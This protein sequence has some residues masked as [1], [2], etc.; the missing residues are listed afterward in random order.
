[1][2]SGY[3]YSILLFRRCKLDSFDERFKHSLITKKGR[4]VAEYITNNKDKVGFMTANAIAN[5]LGISDVTVIR[6]ARSLGYDG[7]SDMQSELQSLAIQKINGQP[8]FSASPGAKIT[9][10]TPSDENAV[11]DLVLNNTLFNID[12]MI[13]R[14]TTRD[15]QQAADIIIQSRKKYVIGFL[16]RSVFSTHLA[17][18]LRF[19]LSDVINITSSS[20]NALIPLLDISSHDCVILYSYNKDPSKTLEVAHICKDHGAKIIIITDNEAAQVNADSDASLIAIVDG[21]SFSNYLAVHLL[22]DILVTTIAKQLG[23]D[24]EA[25]FKQ[26]KSLSEHVD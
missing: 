19:L 21:I 16:A 17:N 13:K 25:R 14:N 7:Y 2:K 1:M 4:L 5:E 11:K 24:Q 9:A 3:D 12:N 23:P 10:S 18:D 20:S 22:G 8:L 6:F 26:I 15:F